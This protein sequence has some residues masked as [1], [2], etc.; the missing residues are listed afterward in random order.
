VIAQVNDARWHNARHPAFTAGDNVAMG[1]FALWVAL[2]LCTWPVSAWAWDEQRVL[3]YVMGHNPVIRA[4]RTVTNE[5]TPP[6]GLWG[7]MKEYTNAYGRAGVGGTDFISGEDDPFVLQAGVQLSIPLASSKERREHAMKMVEETRA[8]DQVRAKVLAE[9]GQLRQHEA[10]L[11]ASETRLEFLESQSTWLQ[12]RVEDGFSDSAELWDIGKK[13]HE[14]RATAARLR[15]LTASE[16]YQLA[17]YAGDQ[18]QTLL[19]YLEGSG[20]I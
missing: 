10:D 7:R 18:W 6:D 11:T 16:R 14:E 9:M 20:D 1:R 13:L 5:F 12:R 2:I 17:S 3:E 8:I 19:R 15:T 4:Q